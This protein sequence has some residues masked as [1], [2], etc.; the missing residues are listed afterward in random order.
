MSRHDPHGDWRSGAGL[1]RRAF[2]KSCGAAPLAGAGLGLL[3]CGLGFGPLVA[4]SLL[5][6][7]KEVLPKHVTPE[8]LRAVTKGLDYLA[9]QQ[10][11]DGSWNTGGGQAYPVAM[12]GLAGTA[13]LAHGNSPTRG[14]YSRNLQGAVEFL[15]RCTTPTGLITG[16]SQDSGQPMHGHGFALM[17]LASVYGM[18]TKESLR[19]QVA[20]TIRKA[21]T[22]TSQGQ[23]G[24]GGWTYIPG[25]G[26][27]G[28][29]TVTQVQALR[30]AQN[31]GFLVP[32]AVIDESMNYL[33]KCRTPEGGIQYSLS[34]G[35]GPRLAISAAAVATLY[36]AGQ[37]ES[38]I[39]TDCL[40]YVWG[41]FRANEGWN[42]GGG[43]AFYSHLYAAQGFYM[44]GDEYW[45]QYFPA[46]RDQLIA[47]Q[48]GDGSWNGDG[49]GQVYGTS[50][51]VVI[52]QLPYKYLPVFQ[53]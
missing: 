6:D 44:A 39:A 38:P 17:F 37:F 30:A 7:E 3:G 43:H 24:A 49:I 32:K 50:I 23:S 5:A 12:T 48:G 25:G 21:V 26:D 41:Q 1:A 15:V 35:G 34:A 14:K 22:L 13:L 47:M 52:L 36:N 27:E 2:L 42:K 20:E 16:P 4:R 31:A 10:A 51:A 29:V 9:A 28:S 33:E 19:R 46:T 8:A 18:I 11:D 40:K 53:R 45:D